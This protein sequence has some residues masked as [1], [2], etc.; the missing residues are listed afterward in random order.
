MNG[1]S[2]WIS[3]GVYGVG[4]ALL[5]RSASAADKAPSQETSSPPEREAKGA[6]PGESKAVEL[7]LQERRGKAIYLRGSSGE[8]AEITAI[9]G[10]ED[11][12]EVPASSLPCGGCH[13]PDGR[14]RPEGGVSPADIRPAALSSPLEAA[15]AGLRERPPYD[16]HA[17]LTAVTQGRDPA[18]NQLS[19]SMPRYRL[20]REDAQALL[21]FMKRL[22][23][24]VD[25]GVEPNRIILGALLPP[26]GSPAGLA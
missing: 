14:G 23:T 6:R 12:V 26:P 8:Q 13:G 22:G 19:G 9:F 10:T 15:S 1:R 21:A 20:S 24:C 4:L 5:L 16:D 3:L 7:T 2:G 11:P 25:P 17:L 18:G